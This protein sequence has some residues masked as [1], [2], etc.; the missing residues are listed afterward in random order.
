VNHTIVRAVQWPW[1]KIPQIITKVACL[2]DQ[3]TT[4][5]WVTCFGIHWGKQHAFRQR[6]VWSIK[7][8]WRA[9]RQCDTS[10][11]EKRQMCDMGCHVTDTLMQSYLSSISISSAGVAEAAAER[12]TSCL[13]LSV[14]LVYLAMAYDAAGLCSQEN[15][16]QPA[17][18]SHAETFSA[19]V[20]SHLMTSYS[21]T[22]WV[23]QLST[24]KVKPIRILM[25]L[26]MMGWQYPQL[27]YMQ[28]ICTSLQTSMP[29]PHHCFYRPDA[30]PDAQP[31]VSKRWKK[32][33]MDGGGGT[34]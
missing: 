23:S 9:T 19:S 6:I 32:W 3:L 29:T 8:Q 26:E 31:T 21:R 13:P 12:T 24:R 33:M 14:I 2:A 15:G 34:G 20:D 1:P 7:I 5:A 28:I 30:L 18:C 22:T 16:T 4:T 10:P 25:R 17:P 11:V 27:D